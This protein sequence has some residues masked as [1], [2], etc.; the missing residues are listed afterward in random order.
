[1]AN[2]SVKV[3]I[4]RKWNL[5]QMWESGWKINKEVEKA[6]GLQNE[7]EGNCIKL[8]VIQCKSEYAILPN[9]ACNACTY[10]I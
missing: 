8:E 10:G 5:P 3:L 1:M 9:E 6:M 7:R 4:H 2:T